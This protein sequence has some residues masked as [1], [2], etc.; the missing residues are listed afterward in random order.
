MSRRFTK[1]ATLL[2]ALGI[3]TGAWAATR[4]G[5]SAAPAPA[6]PHVAAPAPMHGSAAPIAKP[7]IHAAIA[8]P[9]IG[10]AASPKAV[11]PPTGAAGRPG[12][13]AAAAPVAAG[14]GATSP[15]IVPDVSQCNAGPATQQGSCNPAQCVCV[16]Q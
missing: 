9:S 3:S 6:A 11:D 4:I 14:A 15:V 8:R 10:T 7:A 12:A 16:G 13:A 2:V 5:E 1:L